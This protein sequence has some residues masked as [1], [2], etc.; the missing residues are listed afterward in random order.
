MNNITA[1]L[2]TFLRPGYTKACI[3][4]LQKE[5]KDIK[6]IVGENG[7]Y[8]KK[9]KAFCQARGVKYVEMPYD[10]GV[11][12]A[13][14]R[15]VELV[16]T[17]YVLIGDDDFYYDENAGVEKML[18]F[19]SSHNEFDLIGGRVSVNGEVGNYQG[20][21]EK[22]FDHLNTI[23]LDLNSEFNFDEKSRLRYLQVDL[24]FNYFLAR[25]GKVKQVKWDEEIKVAYEHYSWFADFK[26]AGHKVAFSPD[27]IVVHKPNW[28]KSEQAQEYLAF[29]TRKS[30][31]ERFFERFNI[32][33]HIG[34]NG[35]RT[36]APNYVAEVKAND[37][38][39]VDFCIT[40]FER[41]KALERLL[42]SI[43]KFYP[44]A[45]V[46]VAD[47]SKVFDR[48]FYKKLRRQIQGAGLIKRL[49][50]DQ[51]PYDCGL[52]YARNFLV[53]RTPN[54]YKLILDDDF[55]F[56]TETD[57]GKF[58]RILDDFKEVGVVGGLVKQNGVD[59]NFEFNLE[60]KDKTIHHQADGNRWKDHN[61][62]KY[63]RTG[64]VLN[65]A[66]FRAEL[67]N[68]V[69]WDNNLKVTEHTDFY[70]RLKKTSWHIFYTPDVVVDHPPVERSKE[71]KELRQR[72][73]FLIMMFKKHGVNR[74]KYLNGQ[75][76]ELEGDSVIKKY[77]EHV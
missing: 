2:I 27:P 25:T 71:Y 3:D 60:I 61:G 28:V 8:S 14:N 65:F 17:E 42:I 44:M 34:M 51:L 4:S 74:M 13:R 23:A 63:K 46:Y 68:Q 9:M 37:T 15:L 57:I 45:N 18:K 55:E 1:I 43:A 64:C 62:I 26:E 73:T 38:K 39:F 41:P 66:L 30:D 19:L 29:R 21:I 22:H 11:C 75:V 10:S 48:V 35:V 36:Y 59:V 76:Y 70:L 52:S 20:F 47:Q 40:T 72:D 6:I 24:T 33:Y 12:F 32:N 67:L 53:S 49:S 5:Y 7:N 31:K 58:V 54:K 69:R 16:D 56:T 77:K 50:I